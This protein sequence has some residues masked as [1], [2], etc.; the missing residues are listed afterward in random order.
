MDGNK[1]NINWDSTNYLNTP[2]KCWKINI[3]KNF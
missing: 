1:T 3:F 2:G